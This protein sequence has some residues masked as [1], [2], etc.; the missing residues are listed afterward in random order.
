MII[1]FHPAY[2]YFAKYF[3]KRNITIGKYESIRFKNGTD[4]ISLKTKVLGKSCAVI[5]PSVPGEDL[6]EFLLLSHT[7]K[8]EGARSVL[9]VFPNIPYARQD[10]NKSMESWGANWLGEVCKASGITKI[11]T[12][13]IHSQEAKKS[14]L[15]PLISL[16]ASNI[17]IKSVKKDINEN[18]VCV[19]PDEGAIDNCSEISSLLDISQPVA[20]F[21][22]RR[23]KSGI[24]MISLKGSIKERVILV[25]D[26]LDTGETLLAASKYLRKK[27]VVSIDII[28]THGLFTDNM[29]TEL[30]QNGVRKIYCTDSNPGALAFASGKVIV[31]SCGDI[32]AKYFNEAENFQD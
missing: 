20:H 7:L 25:D 32:F 8:K 21:T 16:S 3:I 4:F 12:L 13:D 10:K 18:A 2:R 28:V 30:F 24:K 15:I 11:I 6:S 23:T 27:G 29:W 22:K 31:S 1:F 5:G 19:A 26:I 17:L 14:F 9:V